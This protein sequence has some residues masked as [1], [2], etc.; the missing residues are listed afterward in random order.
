MRKNRKD[1]YLDI[2]LFKEYLKT[3]NEKYRNG[4]FEVVSETAPGPKGKVLLKDKYGFCEVTRGK[5]IDRG[6]GTSIQSAIDK[7]AYSV[8][9]F[10]EVHGN[11]YDYSLFTTYGY[12]SS[13]IDIICK[14]HGVFKQVISDHYSGYGCYECGVETRSESRKYSIKEFIEKAQ[15]N[16]LV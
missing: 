5:L 11:T 2:E 14:K 10:R 13:T 9:R 15:E 12:R 3:K 1:V 8:N 7:I 6:T 4:E 16:Y